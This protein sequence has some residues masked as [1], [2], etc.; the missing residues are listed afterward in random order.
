MNKD[1]PPSLHRLRTLWAKLDCAPDLTR[2]SIGTAL[3]LSALWIILLV[4][5]Y[6]APTIDVTVAGLFFRAQACGE[7]LATAVCGDFPISQN[8]IAKLVRKVLFYLPHVM[9]VC[10]LVA[11]IVQ[12][13]E[14]KD[15]RVSAFP[16]LKRRNHDWTVKLSMALLSMLI[17]PILIVN[18]VLKEWSGRPR[19][20]Q[21]S[22]FGGEFPFVP[23]GS[24][25]GACTGNCSFISGEAAGAGLLFCL[26]A[27]LPARWRTRFGPP[28]VLASIATPLLRVA[29]GGHYLSDA[30]FGWLSSPLV[31]AW[32][33]AIYHLRTRPQKGSHSAR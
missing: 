18:V 17:G 29:F 10:L 13:L 31:F 22:L 12:L 7:G 24:F 8:T 32:V 5:F 15:P 23:A 30:I 3:G 9:T 20:V 4:L 14:A 6:R 19:P 27:L 2:A 21:T 25:A 28:L 16:L 1:A 11:L 26:V 33:F